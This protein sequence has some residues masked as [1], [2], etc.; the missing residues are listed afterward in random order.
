MMNMILI[1]AIMMVSVFG[2]IERD[3]PLPRAVFSLNKNPP[4]SFE[5]SNKPNIASTRKSTSPVGINYKIGYPI[6]TGQVN[7]YHI[8]YGDWNNAT[9]TW[10]PNGAGQSLVEDFAQNVGVS[11]WYNINRLYYYQKSSTTSKVYASNIVKYSGGVVDGYSLGADKKSLSDAEISQIVQAH[12]KDFNGGVVDPNGI[13]FV[14]TSPDVTASSGFC[15]KYCGWHTY[16]SISNVRTK[17]SF[18]GVPPSGCPCFA[19][20]SGSP[21]QLVAIDSFISV[22][23]HELVETV[24]DPELNAWYDA[25]GYE[26]ADKCA[27]RFYILIIV[28][29]GNLLLHW[30]YCN[31]VLQ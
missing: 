15:T 26:N 3:L 31:W 27:V 8:Y 9:A 4:P 2:R 7:L 14:L 20:T 10:N 6:I 18:V 17:Y 13:Y 29:M 24:S 12:I 19:Q 16:A 25:T 23:A 5:N 1:T 30:D 21:N 22:Y 11:T 28:E